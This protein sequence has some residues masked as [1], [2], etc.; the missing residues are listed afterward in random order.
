MTATKSTATKSSMSA[1]VADKI[2]DAIINAA[3]DFGE[4]LSEENLAAAFDV[5]RTP[6]REALNLLQ[7]EGLV[8]IVP[9][10]GTYVFTPSLEDIIELCE[11]RAC[12]E[13]QA[14]EL[15]AMRNPLNLAAALERLLGQ[16]EQAVH[17]GDI[18]IYG[19]LDTQYHLAFLENAGNRYL[20]Q[21]YRMIMGRVATLR[22]QLA[23]HAKNEPKRSMH[24]HAMMIQLIRENKI[25]R[26]KTVLWT[27]IMRTSDNF[28][29]AFQDNPIKPLTQKEVVRRKLQQGGAL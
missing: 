26:L 15:S 2:R 5:S 25:S 29:Q 19:Q 10:S 21:G 8:N 4:A 27:H 3:F 17:D 20:M 12:L 1:E 28:M 22:T 24:D 23:L 7:L 16:M 11:Y 6:I 18:R 14:A 9:K 13:L